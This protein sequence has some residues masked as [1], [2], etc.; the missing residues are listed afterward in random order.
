MERPDFILSIDPD[1]S[2]SGVVL[3]D[4]RAKKVLFAEALSFP[5]AIDYIEVV[6]STDSYKPL[7]VVIEDSDVSVNWHYRPGDSK[8]VIAAKG[9]GVGMCHATIRHLREFC[10]H[11]GISPVMKKPLRKC[12][13]GTDGKI[14]HNEIVQFV[15]GL[16]NRTNQEV[17][18][19][20][21]LAWV[22]AALPIK[23]SVK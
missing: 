6:N 17:R 1:V 4:V 22:Q 20:A 10:E 7:A 15:G 5:D 14:T 11:I 18:D 12:W 16:P 9:R 21:L 2:K 13:K 19:A 3:L 23:F 8:G